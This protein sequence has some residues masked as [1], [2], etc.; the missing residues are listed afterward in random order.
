M[1]AVGAPYAALLSSLKVGDLTLKNRIIMSAMTR[2]R[3]I[4]NVPNDMNRAYYEQRA[5]AGLII[6]EGVPIDKRG[7]AWTDVP[8]IYT[9]EMAEGWKRVTDGVHAKGGLIF[10][11]LWHMGRQAHSSF[12][13]GKLPVGPSPLKIDSPKGVPNADGEFV[14]YEVPHAL[15]VDEI[16]EIV[17]Q[18]KEAALLAKAAGFDGIEMHAANG[19]L[20]D[21]FL[22]SCSNQR[23]DEYGG[24]IENRYRFLDQLMDVALEVFPKER[25]G[26]RISPNTNFGGS[27]SPDFRETF[28]YV[29]EQVGKREV[30][31]LQVLDGLAFGFHELGEPMTLDEFR[32][33]VSEKTKIFG[34]VGY[35]PESGEE[36]I[37]SGV[38]DAITYGRYFLSNPDFPERL[39][40]NWPLNEPPEHAAWFTPDLPN[41]EKYSTS[42]GYTE[43]LPYPEEAKQAASA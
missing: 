15:T 13:D 1:P 14:P 2:A 36:A 23:T 7:S 29:A 19:Y 38:A 43:Y 18:Y 34:N 27:G 12:F 41:R 11:Q 22:Q 35:T 21:Q 33:L 40:N 37:T 25:V 42:W 3:S 6:T 9:E 8:G 10:A 39:A 16:Q 20:V 30:A 31:Y 17:Q 32:P 5:G 28:T 24:S 4:N 26:V